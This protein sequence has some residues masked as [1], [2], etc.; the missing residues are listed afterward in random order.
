MSAFSPLQQ[1]SL[2]SGCE[3]LSQ[4][5]ADL[6]ARLTEA[7]RSGQLSRTVSDLAPVERRILLDY[8][9]GFRQELLRALTENG[10]AIGAP[11]ISLRW[12]LQTGLVGMHVAV[13]DLGPS[14][15]RGY[16]ELTPAGQLAAERLQQH[17]SRIID[18]AYR[19]LAQRSGV[20]FPER[21]RRLSTVMPQL[22]LALE[23]LGEIVTRRG[24][25][26]F[27]P[28]LEIILNRMENVRLEI[29]VF[30]HV[31]SGKSSLLNH[32]AGQ[33]LL[34]VGILPVTA[35]PTRLTWG[36]EARVHVEFAEGER[37]RVD[38]SELEQFASEAQ[39]PGNTRHVTRIEAQLPSPRLHEGIV[40]VDTPG[41]GSLARSGSAETLAYLP[42]CDLGLVLIDATS[43]INDEDIKVIG[44]LIAAATPVQ[45]LLSKADGLNDA[46]RWQVQEYVSRTLRDELGV[47]M[48]VY[49]V[50]II[51]QYEPLLYQ[52]F[53][54]EIRPLR[55]HH[56]E[57]SRASIARKIVHLAKSLL[58]V[59]S[60]SQG[61]HDAQSVEAKRN[62]E[63]TARLLQEGDDVLR[64]LES[65]SSRWRFKEPLEVDAIFSHAAEKLMASKGGGS[66]VIASVR[67]AVNAAL[68]DH[69]RMIWH[70]MKDA[71]LQ[72]TQVLMALAEA[73]LPNQIDAMGFE[74]L[75]LEALPIADWTPAR[76]A[77]HEV[78]H[79]WEIFWPAGF[80]AA[81]Q[82]R[83]EKH[84]SHEVI[85][86]VANYDRR[87][88]AWLRAMLRSMRATYEAQTE[89]VRGQ[90]R[91]STPVSGAVA[92][93]S[94]DRIDQDM[95][96]LREIS[97]V[98]DAGPRP[99]QPSSINCSARVG[100]RSA[101]INTEG[102]I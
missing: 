82:H 93:R 24:L 9:S 65:F 97:E 2:L 40:F 4:R 59:L 53:D 19:L 78:V 73:S 77:A 48:P 66:Q 8:F 33:D 34:P 87:L 13:D 55:E 101:T 23:Q 11:R 27:R 61:G 22:A 56:D 28:Q 85:E 43:T 69:A 81:L 94:A 36:P 62:H 20:I 7:D 30:G 88:N 26:E 60:L 45:V 25:I 80:D 18:Q 76:N 92:S 83:L 102:A 1:K 86:A 49:P 31:S 15:L 54:R 3:S 63:K 14:S 100:N 46:Q 16:G 70:R 84:Y 38:V 41:L 10:I 79:W 99:E 75:A 17:L 71:H 5:V 51:G 96:R 37:R 12:A 91:S 44:L 72:L 32:V 39:N 95:G 57:L 52:W 47:S 98:L 42:R 90:S 64:H 68:A 58:S 35:V 21:L 6:E 89:I 74:E 50:S 67:H 29:A